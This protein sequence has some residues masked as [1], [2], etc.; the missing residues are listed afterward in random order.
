MQIQGLE[1][2]STRE[3]Q[4]LHNCVNELGA[5]LAELPGPLEHLHGEDG[6]HGDQPEIS[7]EH[8]AMQG[9]AENVRLTN[10]GND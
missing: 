2:N 9:V 4:N 3:A 8:S 6:H 1:L 7:D 10:L 5:Q